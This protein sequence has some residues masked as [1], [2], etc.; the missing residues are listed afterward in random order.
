MVKRLLIKSTIR[1]LGIKYDGENHRDILNFCKTTF[2]SDK[3]YI[4][5]NGNT[6][7]VKPNQWVVNTYNDHFIVLTD[8]EV[9]AIFR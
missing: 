4:T 6:F 8:A 2:F 9:N 7:E 1:F 5:I 3:L